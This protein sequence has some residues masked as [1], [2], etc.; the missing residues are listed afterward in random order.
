MPHH[1]VRHHAHVVRTNKKFRKKLF[2]RILLVAAIVEPLATLPQLYNIWVLHEAHGVSPATWALY[3]AGAWVWF[4]HGLQL[5]DKPLIIS[6]ALWI[7]T[8][9][10]VA[11]GAI[12]YS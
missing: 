4:F 10:V 1:S 6:G 3:V 8:E 11:L 2:L 9:S 12:I 7:I 5:K